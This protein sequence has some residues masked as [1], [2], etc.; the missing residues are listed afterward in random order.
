MRYQVNVAHMHPFRKQQRT[1]KRKDNFT[2]SLQIL[3]CRVQINA[4]KEQ[5]IVT[6][7]F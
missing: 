1:Q 3:L 2:N 4:N 5:I 7:T 6:K